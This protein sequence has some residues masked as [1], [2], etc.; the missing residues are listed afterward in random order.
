MLLTHASFYQLVF[1]VLGKSQGEV[2]AFTIGFDD[3]D[4]DESAIAT[5]MAESCNA[6]QDIMR[7]SGN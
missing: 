5:E 4:Y 2:K 7:L 6:E 3:K 1:L